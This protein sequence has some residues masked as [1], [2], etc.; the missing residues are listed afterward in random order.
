MIVSCSCI[1]VTYGVLGGLWVGP[2]RVVT[3]PAQQ[4]AHGLT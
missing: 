1:A 3:V 2:I 4:D